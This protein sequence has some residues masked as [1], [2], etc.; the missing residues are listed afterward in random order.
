MQ[1]A[2]EALNAQMHALPGRLRPLPGIKGSLIIDDSYNAAPAAMAHGLDVLKQFTP[3]ERV[4]RRIAAL[5][6]MAELG[7][8]DEQEHRLIG[9]KVAECADVFV[10]VGNRMA[11]AIDAAKEA[12]MDGEL[13][14]QPNS[15]GMSFPTS[16]HD[17]W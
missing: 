13:R 7:S 4:D 5:G 9:M 14:P 11:P 8:Y 1:S 10:A 6:E 12:G 2:I 3:G 15:V 16:K 17:F